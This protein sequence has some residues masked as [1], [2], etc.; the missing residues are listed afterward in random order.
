VLVLAK[1]TVDVP[2]ELLGQLYIRVG[3]ALRRFQEDSADDVAE[4]PDPAQDEDRD[5]A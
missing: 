5:E 2:E 1:V 3:A 4:S